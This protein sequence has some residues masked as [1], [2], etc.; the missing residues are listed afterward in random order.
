MNQYLTYEEMREKAP[1]TDE[2]WFHDVRGVYMSVGATEKIEEVPGF[3]RPVGR[4]PLEVRIESCE[5]GHLSDN[6]EY[7]GKIS[8]TQAIRY[9]K[10]PQ[11]RYFHDAH[12]DRFYLW[13]P[14]CRNKLVLDVGCGL[15]YGTRIMSRSAKE[16][17]G[18]DINEDEVD[19]AIKYHSAPNITYVKGKVESLDMGLFDVA[20]CT[21][22]LEHVERKDIPSLL[23]GIRKQMKFKGVVVF[24]TPCQYVTQKTR[25]PHHVIEYS[26]VDFVSMIEKFFKPFSAAWYDWKDGSVS[27]RFKSG[28]TPGGQ[29]SIVQIIY[30]EVI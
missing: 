22:V 12:I 6:A 24:T 11:F 29:S 4:Y 19:Y 23:A 9:N 2:I 13:E 8:F 18:I 3:W 27:N 21:E 17:V 26:Y 15:A 10:A 1:V 14:L 30:A 5:N 25:N 16:I 7:S 28:G 20:I